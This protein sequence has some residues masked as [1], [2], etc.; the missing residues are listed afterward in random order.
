M[1]WKQKGLV[2]FSRIKYSII[3]IYDS[4]SLDKFRFDLEY[5]FF[6]RNFL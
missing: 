2:I 4:C 1:K 5:D 3:L 6:V